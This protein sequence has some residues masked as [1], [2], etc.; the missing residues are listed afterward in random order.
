MSV[1][2]QQS[3]LDSFSAL[4]R[5]IKG[6]L[7]ACLCVFLLQVLGLHEWLVVHFGLWPDVSVQTVGPGGII[8]DEQPSRFRYWQ[9][10]TYGFLHGG[11]AHLLL[12]LF[13]VFL[14][15]SAIE[16]RWGTRHFLTYYF[17]CVIGAGF[18]QLLVT[19]GE[20]PF[21]TIGASGGLFGLLLA[22]GLTFP[23]QKLVFLFLPYPIKA[24]YAVFI[25]GAIELGL[26]V[27]NLQTGI[28][29]FAHLGGMLTGILYLWYIRALPMQKG[30][31]RRP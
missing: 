5:A 29:H 18:A 30:L 20:F 14:F 2:A 26:G 27:S 3:F 11:W 6:L 22:F 31:P 16:R 12:N 15:G 1:T 9:L 7:V 24:K 21:P 10:L 23:E 13:G 8:V 28:A 4:P 17:V 25:Y 19:Y